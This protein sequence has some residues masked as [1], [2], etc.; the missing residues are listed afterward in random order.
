VASRASA[1]AREGAPPASA[2]PLR[3]F[4]PTHRAT[5][6]IAALLAADAR[7]GDVIFLHG[8]VGAGKSAFARAFV[9][10]VCRDARMEVPSPTFL[11]QQ[12]YDAYDPTL[13][14]PVHH[15]DLYRLETAAEMAKLGLE[16]SFAR[17]A[18]VVEWAERLE[19]T[20]MEPTSR[21]D[22]FVA[23][24]AAE[25][26]DGKSASSSAEQRRFANGPTTVLALTGDPDEE[27]PE[28][29]DELDDELDD[30]DA[31]PAFLD[32]RGRMFTLEPRGEAWAR[33]VEKIRDACA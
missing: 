19:G 26:E 7:A 30:P 22:V 3:L 5:A 1:D 28:A 11:L 32:R 24:A 2:P 21:L 16:D 18:S 10:A 14:P 31:D 9:R 8:D 29:L 20:P 17:A 25:E 13:G 23:V 6:R 33:R 27:D 4:A 15:F 12:V